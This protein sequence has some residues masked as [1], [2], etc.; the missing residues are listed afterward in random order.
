MSVGSLGKDNTTVVSVSNILFKDIQ[1]VDA[2]YGARF[3]SWTGGKGLASN[4][5]WENFKL[6]NVSY[7][8]YVTQTYNK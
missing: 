3:K 6:Q 2:L 5:T 8:I 4:I 1:L 7:P